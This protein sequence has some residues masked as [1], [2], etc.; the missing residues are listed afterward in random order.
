MG[1]FEDVRFERT[2]YESK[3]REIDF[4]ALGADMENVEK[5]YKQKTFESKSDS[6]ENIL[7][8]YGPGE[9]VIEYLADN[10]VGLEGGQIIK[11][12][13]RDGKQSKRFLEY[14][15]NNFGG[16]SRTPMQM[17]Q[18]FGRIPFAVRE[19][20]NDGRVLNLMTGVHH[21]E[22]LWRE[23]FNIFIEEK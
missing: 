5:P 3:N 9:I 20:I 10:F 22:I 19:S 15:L 12:K 14:A 7:E 13:T 17:Y 16:L 2:L 8:T 4:E 6:H 18:A 1:S 11:A 21:P 23:M